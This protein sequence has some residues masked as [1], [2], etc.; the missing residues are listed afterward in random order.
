MSLELRNVH[1]S[2]GGHDAVS[3]VS[4]AFAQARVTGL[5]GPNGSGKTT[6]LKLASGELRPGEGM[7]I[8]DGCAVRDMPAKRR[9]RRIAVVPQ[10]AS[11]DFDFTVLD[12]VLM[13]RQPHLARLQSEGGKD[14][15]LA[16]A[17]MV[18]MGIEQLSDRNARG[19][20]GGEWQRV[21]IARA[22]CQDTEVLLLDEPVSSLDI[23]HQMDVLS[24]IRFLTREKQMTVAVVLHDLNLAAHYCDALALMK[25]G[26]LV[27]QGGPEAVLTAE[28]MHAVYG[29]E[30]V[31]EATDGGIQVRP[32][33]L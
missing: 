23:R 5:I 32:V 33:Y 26:R 2:Y 15:E 13:G 9:A 10:R 29:I 4:C 30:A 28:R 7:A 21:L 27:A 31:I 18:R 17:A 19:L 24:A 6:L 16:R 11:L 12:M 20:S 25:D 14:L 8:L 3:G 1:Y 22:L